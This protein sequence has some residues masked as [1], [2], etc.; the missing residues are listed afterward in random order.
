MVVHLRVLLIGAFFIFTTFVDGKCAPRTISIQYKA[1]GPESIAVYRYCGAI[2]CGAP[3][4][5]LSSPCSKILCPRGVRCNW[6][7]ARLDA[8]KLPTFYES[9]TKKVGRYGVKF[10]KESCPFLALTS[11]WRNGA[12]DWFG[13]NGFITGCKPRV[14]CRT[15]GGK[16][17]R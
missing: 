10:G 9:G 8:F 2:L 7:S 12:S 5:T 13:R 6:C 14:A 3:V 15:R 1:E 16:A 4:V 11:D 17:C